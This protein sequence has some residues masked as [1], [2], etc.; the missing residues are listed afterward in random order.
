MPKVPVDTTC[1][2]GSM[3]SSLWM[4]VTVGKDGHTSLSLDGENSSVYIYA[5]SPEELRRTLE[6]ALGLLDEAVAQKRSGAESGQD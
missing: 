3:F 6:T 5:D 2:M 4:S 1:G